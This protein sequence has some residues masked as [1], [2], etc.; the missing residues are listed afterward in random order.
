MIPLPREDLARRRRETVLP[1]D[2]YGV[3]SLLRFIVV[4]RPPGNWHIRESASWLHA[5]AIIGDNEALTHGASTSLQDV[6]TNSLL[7]IMQCVKK[8]CFQR[9]Q[10]QSAEL[11]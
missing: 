8:M 6:R 2:I 10:W 4:S 1:L 7:L 5:S 9:E 3:S 11:V